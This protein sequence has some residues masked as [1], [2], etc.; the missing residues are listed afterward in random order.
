[1]SMDDNPYAAGILLGF[2]GGGTDLIGGDLAAGLAVVLVV[3]TLRVA[4]HP[5]V[6]LSQGGAGEGGAGF[7]LLLNPP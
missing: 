3:R 5:H 2:G 4:P 6:N 1:M 7:K